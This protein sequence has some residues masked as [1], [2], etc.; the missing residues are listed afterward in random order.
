MDE[1]LR[2]GEVTWK[3]FKEK[4]SETGVDDNEIV[5]FMHL[6]T[7][8]PGGMTVFALSVR[9]EVKGVFKPEKTDDVKAI[10]YESRIR[11]LTEDLEKLRA[12]SLGD[13]R[14]IWTLQSQIDTMKNLL[15]TCQQKLF[16][17]TFQKLKNLDVIH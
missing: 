2:P 1:E 4:M 15:C 6:Y 17:I 5:K 12:E 16:D 10:E 13:K 14:I 8:E 3:T 9:R 7:Q 11:H